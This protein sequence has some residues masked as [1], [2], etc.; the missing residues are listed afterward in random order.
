MWSDQYL[1]SIANL[2]SQ[3]ESLKQAPD[4]TQ[5]I[6]LRKARCFSL[7]NRPIEA[8][9]L[10]EPLAKAQTPLAR[11]AHLEWLSTARSMHAWNAAAKI[12]Q[13]F[14]DKYP[15]DKDV[16]HVLFW[17][18]LSQIEQEDYP[19]AIASLQSLIAKA[20]DP[21]L[22]AAALYYLGFSQYTLGNTSAAL[23]AFEHC[24]TIDPTLPVAAQ[25]SLWIG[26]CQLT[27]NK[28]ED[29]IST[30]R[31]IQKNENA[32]ALHPEASFRESAC[33]YALGELETAF[34]QTSSW[35]TSYPNH[36]REAEVHFLR[37]DILLEQGQDKQAIAA[38]ARVETNDPQ[39]TFIALEKRASLL[40]ESNAPSDALAIL[41]A[42]RSEKSPV[43]SP[44][45]GSYTKLLAACLAP[46]D[47]QRE[48]SETVTSYGNDLSAQGIVELIQL[49]PSIPPAPE[50]QSTLASRIL[51]AQIRN[52]RNKGETSQAELKSLELASSFDLETLPPE[53]LIEA[54]N[55]LAAIASTETAKYFQR[56]LSQYPDSQYSDQAHLGLARHYKN[57]ADPNTAL[58]HLLQTTLS[59]PEI[60]T[61]KLELE[62][63]LEQFPNAQQTAELLL[64]D[65]QA[66]PRDK[67][68]AILTLGDI[69]LHEDSL[70]KA[71]TYYQ[72]IFT[73]YRGETDLVATAYQNSIQILA[74]QNRQPDAQK[75][76]TEFLAQTDL[77]TQTA[78]LEIQKW[79]NSSQ[80][81]RTAE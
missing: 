23:Y 70:D 18:A 22:H 13:D 68:Q 42:Y 57:Q 16:P 31:Q 11:E 45:I 69:A 62:L 21:A 12:A 29:A 53:A 46:S 6:D 26:I 60:L 54:G 24:R 47:A 78:Y 28:V 67:A 20:P 7:I 44:Y 74:S 41:Q 8:W 35:L 27:T 52:H 5:A 14:L 30:F 59:S 58:A 34:A 73:L 19:E 40:I 77:S 33:L 79:L 56:I 51:V 63:E 71:Y 9:I 2:Q 80:T 36:A 15:N 61:L 38:Y 72:R 32:H 3:L 25:A 76:A 39:L 10:L 65:R 4:Y 17:I 48:I 43:P 75:V 50:D 1:Q 66:S 64:A 55:A 81:A 49:L 37:G